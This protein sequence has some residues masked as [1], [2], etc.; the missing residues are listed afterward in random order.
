MTA[1]HTRCHKLMSLKE[2]ASNGP[3]KGEQRSEQAQLPCVAT[4]IVLDGLSGV[5]RLNHRS[6]LRARTTLEGKSKWQQKI[7]LQT[8]HGKAS[9]DASH[10][11]IATN[12]QPLDHGIEVPHEPRRL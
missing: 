10:C 2:S 8:V 5:H 4:T 9:S 6:T 11:A 12:A 3:W 7:A 1:K